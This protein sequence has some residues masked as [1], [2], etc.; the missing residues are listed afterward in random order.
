[1][2]IN[3]LRQWGVPATLLLSLYVPP[4]RPISYITQTLREGLSLADNIKLKRTLN[5]VKRAIAA[6]NEGRGPADGGPAPLGLTAAHET[7]GAV[8]PCGKR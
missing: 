1:E 5:A 2:A 4:G 8:S 7:V 6:A 3:E